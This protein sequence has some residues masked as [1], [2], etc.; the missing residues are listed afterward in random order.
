MLATRAS[1]GQEAHASSG[2]T[3]C[4][5][6]APPML[7]GWQ[8]TPGVIMPRERPRRQY[9]PKRQG[10]PLMSDKSFIADGERVLVDLNALRA[11]GAYRTGVHRPTFSEPHM[12]S[13]AWLVERLP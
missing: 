13:L 5:R 6:S 1:G 9:V 3:F 10:P 11:M 4:G 8:H 12:Q 2:S 7:V